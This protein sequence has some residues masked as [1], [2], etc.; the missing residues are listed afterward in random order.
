[1]F[2]VRLGYVFYW[3]VMVLHLSRVILSLWVPV[4]HVVTGWAEELSVALLTLDRWPRRS[5]ELAF[6]QRF[7]FQLNWRRCN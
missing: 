3:V 1:M 4:E 5:A 6:L 7:R 2:N